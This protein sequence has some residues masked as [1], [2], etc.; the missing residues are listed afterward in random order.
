M[1]SS[2]LSWLRSAHFNICEVRRDA[3]GT[4]FLSQIGQALRTHPL[5]PCLSNDDPAK[6]T[7]TRVHRFQLTD[8]EFTILYV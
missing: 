8:S 5:K 1:C 4:D 3:H 6:E 2:D 7:V